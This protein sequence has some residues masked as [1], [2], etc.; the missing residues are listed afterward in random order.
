MN[1]YDFD[2][3]IYKDDSTVDFYFFVLRRHPSV[4]LC[5]PS[6]IFAAVLWT[7]GIIDKTGFKERFYRFL[8][9][10]DDI[11]GDLEDF[12]NVHDN[13]IKTFYKKNQHED[14]VVIS[15][16]PE[17]LLKPIC[18]RLGIKYL[19]ASKVDKISGKYDGINCW[20]DEKPRRFYEAFGKNAVIN[21]FYSDSLSDTPLAEIAKKSFI[22]QGEELVLWE[23]YKPKKRSAFLSR[24]FIL[25]IAVGFV[26]T[27]NGVLFSWIYSLA[28]GANA[29]FVFGYITALA[30]AYVLNSKIIFSEKLG[31]VRYIKFCISYIP[32]FVIQNIAV[33]IFYNML[34]WEKLIVYALAAII[35]IPV[36]FIAVKV[37]AFRK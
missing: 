20:G 2:K 37:F 32:N 17:F 14:D 11:D 34:H 10:I 31:F 30:V 23:E 1:V 36:T 4:I 5:W 29:G 24:E 9:K 18:R 3:T 21:E 13:K 15:A 16:S 7:L 33:L 8:R 19:Y 26:N 12:W 25:F 6:L 27:L 22:V 35:G 28:C